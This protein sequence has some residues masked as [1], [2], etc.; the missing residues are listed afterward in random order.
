MLRSL[1]ASRRSEAGGK[2]GGLYGWR[3]QLAPK[4]SCRF[5]PPGSD[6][7]GLSGITANHTTLQRAF[8]FR[9]AVR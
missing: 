2:L 5:L 3:L 4:S 1:G 6:L 9:V 7:S 8:W